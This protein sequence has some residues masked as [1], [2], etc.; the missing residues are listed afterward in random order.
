MTGRGTVTR[1]GVPRTLSRTTGEEGP[2]PK[3]WVGEGSAVPS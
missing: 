2:G 1:F 3:G